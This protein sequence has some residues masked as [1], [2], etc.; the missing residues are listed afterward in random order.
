MPAPSVSFY[1]M[2]GNI[3]TLPGRPRRSAN[4]MHE[5]SMAVFAAN[6]CGAIP[7]APSIIIIVVGITTDE[8]LMADLLIEVSTT[9]FLAHTLEMP[10][11]FLR[12]ASSHTSI[13]FSISAYRIHIVLQK[14][15]QAPAE[16]PT[17]QLSISSLVPVA[18]FV[19]PAVTIRRNIATLTL[20]EI[21]A[22]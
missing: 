15:A 3:D 4:P 20:D 16:E 14:L 1:E 8:I 6:D 12:S 21:A 22:K 9:A 19:A 13:P 11:F 18:F 2:G 10:I 5:A 7:I 17:R